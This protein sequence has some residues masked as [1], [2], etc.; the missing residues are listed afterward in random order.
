MSYF[1][2]FFGIQVSISIIFRVLYYPCQGQHIVG[3]RAFTVPMAPPPQQLHQ[4]PSAQMLQP[5]VSPRGYCVAPVPGG[6]C[7]LAPAAAQAPMTLPPTPEALPRH[8]VVQVMQAPPS[9]RSPRSPQT[10]SAQ[11]LAVEPVVSPRCH[12]RMVPIHSN[13]SVPLIQSIYSPLRGRPDQVV[14]PAPAMPSQHHRLVASQESL[15][16][17]LKN[18]QAAR[19]SLA[20]VNAQPLNLQEALKRWPCPPSPEEEDR[21][22]PQD[23]LA[24]SEPPEADAMSVSAEPDEPEAPEE[25]AKTTPAPEVKSEEADLLSGTSSFVHERV[26][27]ARSVP[28][29]STKSQTTTGGNSTQLRRRSLMPAVQEEAQHCRAQLQKAAADISSKDLRELRQ[30]VRPPKQVKLVLDTISLL[31]GEKA[32][33]KGYNW[34]KVLSDSLPQKL[35]EFEPLAMSSSQRSKVV[36]AFGED[37]SQE[38]IAKSHQPSIGLSKWC[39]CINSFVVKSNRIMSAEKSVPTSQDGLPSDAAAPAATASQGHGERKRT[40]ATA[41]PVN[42]GTGKGKGR[43]EGRF[44]VEPDLSSLSSSELTQVSEL[45]VTK[46]GVGQVVFHGVTD[47]TDLDV[48]RDIVLKRGFV[49]VYPDQ[50]KK[51]PP[52]QGLNKPASVT[53]YQCFPPGEPV[54]ALSEDAAQGYRDKIKRMTEENSACTFIDYDCQTGV[55]KFE[56]ERF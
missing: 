13:G 25:E 20:N 27:K 2:Y 16:Q 1:A 7:C 56:V 22:R 15:A 11:N 29:N 31:L 19:A 40:P 3:A 46:P 32:G 54:K 38:I 50:T 9:P 8:R 44:I 6:S 14:L 42:G 43:D 30:L 48:G 49:L 53:M 4:C 28:V 10:R 47:C 5:M 36:E 34:K 26:V 21:C 41:T 35:E 55:W 51:P 37:L 33:N 23:D 45:K 39:E 17:Q 24:L 18:L 12:H 52:G